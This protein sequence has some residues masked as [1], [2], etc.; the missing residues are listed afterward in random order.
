MTYTGPNVMLQSSITKVTGL[1]LVLRILR[2]VVRFS[3][4]DESICFG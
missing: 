3:V 1:W 4:G 2:P